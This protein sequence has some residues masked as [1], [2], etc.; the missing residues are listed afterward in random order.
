[1]LDLSLLYH[2][3]LSKNWIKDLKNKFE[4]VEILE[5]DTPKLSGGN[6]QIKQMFKDLFGFKK[7]VKKRF[8]GITENIET[9]DNN[10]EN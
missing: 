6:Y 1:M 10:L 5:Y 3:D 9:K 8:I 4:N 7:E 2:F